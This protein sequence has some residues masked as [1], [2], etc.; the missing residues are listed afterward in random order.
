[1]KEALYAESWFA[2]LLPLAVTTIVLYTI[3]APLIKSFATANIAAEIFGLLL[4]VFILYL[5]QNLLTI[6]E[7]YPDEI[8]FTRFFVF[9]TRILYENMNMCVLNLSQFV[10][11]DPDSVATAYPRGPG[12]YGYIYRIQFLMK[13]G[14]IIK[15]KKVMGSRRAVK[16]SG[17]LSKTVGLDKVVEDITKWPRL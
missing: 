4:F 10:F 3:V 7:I 2:R 6:V 9:K 11:T 17:I 14:S 16:F 8:V 12:Y 5:Y 1:M 13:D 15:V